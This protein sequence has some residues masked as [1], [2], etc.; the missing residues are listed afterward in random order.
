MTVGAQGP[1]FR[2]AGEDGAIGAQLVDERCRAGGAGQLCPAAASLDGRPSGPGE[3]N[4]EGAQVR[5]D[6]ILADIG[7]LGR[8]LQRW[9][10]R[11]GTSRRPG[12]R[13]ST[14]RAAP[15]PPACQQPGQ[16][17][18]ADRA[19]CAVRGDWVGRIVARNGTGTARLP[20]AHNQAACG[21]GGADRLGRRGNSEAIIKRMMIDIS[22]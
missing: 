2:V 16:Q 5:E 11:G 7:V 19:G 9:C 17:V 20:P 13:T 21:S 1:M 8:G 6:L 14:I 22:Y 10:S 18:P 12:R 3:Q 4:G 15:A